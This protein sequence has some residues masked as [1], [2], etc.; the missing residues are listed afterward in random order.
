MLDSR[1]R[2]FKGPNVFA[3]TPGPSQITK[4]SQ[5]PHPPASIVIPIQ[6]PKQLLQKPQ[7][8][9]SPVPTTTKI[10]TLSNF[11]APGSQSATHSDDTI[12]VVEGEFTFVRTPNYRPRPQP[13]QDYSYFCAMINSRI[14]V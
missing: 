1:E 11:M 4:L 14:S 8:V 10:P 3:P 2:T 13:S 5:N 7:H 9:H 6:T 12:E